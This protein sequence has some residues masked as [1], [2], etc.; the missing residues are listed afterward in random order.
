GSKGSAAF[1]LSAN[2]TTIIPEAKVTAADRLIS[3]PQPT[4]GLPTPPHV[5]LIVDATN[6]TY[7]TENPSTHARTNF[8]KFTMPD[9]DV[10]EI[11]VATLTTN[12]YFSRVG[13]V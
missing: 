2:H 12:R 13:T 4:N 9:N 6:S 7:F 10:V 8:I 11:D 5:S 3:E 1:A